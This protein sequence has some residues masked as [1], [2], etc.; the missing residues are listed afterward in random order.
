M[1]NPLERDLEL[2]VKGE[3]AVHCSE[4]PAISI[5]MSPPLATMCC[6]YRVDRQPLERRSGRCCLGI[7]RRNTFSIDPSVPPVA[8]W[9]GS[10]R[11]PHRPPGL[12]VRPMFF[13]TH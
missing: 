3:L 12:F 1:N 13:R 4:I 5:K 9:E 2:T 10:R 11:L 6:R 8:P 7:Q